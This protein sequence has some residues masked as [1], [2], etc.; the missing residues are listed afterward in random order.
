M[1]N[2]LLDRAMA[3]FGKS[4]NAARAV[5]RH[6]GQAGGALER[7]RTDAGHRTADD[8]GGQPRVLEGIASDAAR[9]VDRRTRHALVPTERVGGDAAAT[10]RGEVEVAVGDELGSVGGRDMHS[11]DLYA[12]HRGVAATGAQARLRRGTASEGVQI[13]ERISR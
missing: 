6:G 9:A 11:C 7:V 1:G 10:A 3:P 13:D 2:K 5:D 12:C 8:Q 4:A